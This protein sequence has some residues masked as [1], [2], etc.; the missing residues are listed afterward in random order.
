MSAALTGRCLSEEHK[1][2][3]AELSTGRILTNEAR[4]KISAALK[5]GR[6]SEEHKANLRGIRRSA[7]TKAKLSKA[8]KGTTVSKET[9]AKMSLTMQLKLGRQIRSYIATKA[10]LRIFQAAVR[11]QA[12]NF[13]EV[14]NTNLDLSAHHMYDKASCLSGSPLLTSPLN[15]ILLTSELHVAYHSQNG[16]SHMPCNPESL[17]IFLEQLGHVEGAK[18]VR[19]RSE[20]LSEFIEKVCTSQ[21]IAVYWTV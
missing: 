2:K 11:N 6:L 4:T 13:C 9:R 1:A 19:N 12:Q 10:E 5:G 18:L 17:A 21:N 14:T 8:R 3:L 16:G 7:E 20:L 15:G